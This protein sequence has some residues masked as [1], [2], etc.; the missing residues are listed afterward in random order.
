MQLRLVKVA[1]VQIVTIFFLCVLAFV[2]V[3]E[4]A[5]YGSKSKA[6]ALCDSVPPGSSVDAAIK[7]IQGADTHAKLKITSPPYLGVAF[8]G[9]FLDRWLCSFTT[10]DGKVVAREIRYLD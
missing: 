6:E 4:I 1:L 7:A 8:G 10:A 5:S 9:A 2:G 3:A